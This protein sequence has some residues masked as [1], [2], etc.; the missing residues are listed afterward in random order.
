[1]KSGK[2][3]ENAVTWAAENKLVSGIGNGKFNPDGKVNREQIAVI[4]FRYAGRFKGYSTEKTADLSKYPDC[5]KVSAWAKAALSWANAEGLI[6][7]TVQNGATVLDPQGNAHKSAG[8]SHSD[9]LC[10]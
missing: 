3:Y 7:G 9:V 6:G 4:I 2:Y 5:G 8:C 10:E 1:V